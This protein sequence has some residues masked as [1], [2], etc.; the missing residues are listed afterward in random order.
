MKK[1]LIILLI[2]LATLSVV[3]ADEKKADFESQMISFD[4][5][6]LSYFI[7]NYYHQ[8]KNDAFMRDGDWINSLEKQL[9]LDGFSTT[10]EDLIKV[11]DESTSPINLLESINLIHLENQKNTI[12]DYLECDEIRICFATPYLS[13]PMSY[14]GHIFIEFYNADNPLFSYVLSY[15]G[16]TKDISKFDIYKKGILGTLDGKYTIQPFFNFYDKY[17]V[18]ENRNIISYKINLN[19]DQKKEFKTIIAD[20]YFIHQDYSFIFY[21]CMDGLMDL[22]TQ[23][24]DVNLSSSFINAPADLINKLIESKL[25]SDKLVYASY[26]ENQNNMYYSLS[27]QEK[28]QFNFLMNTSDRVK[29]LESLDSEYRLKLGSL[30]SS[31][32]YY[33]FHH[34]NKYN[35]DYI[36]IINMSVPNLPIVTNDIDTFI[37]TNT[38]FI[39]LDFLSSNNQE[40]KLKLTFRP[41][42]SDIGEQYYSDYSQGA[43]EIGKVSATFNKDEFELEQFSWIKLSSLNRL[44]R[45]KKNMSWNFEL[46]NKLIDDKYPLVIDY[47]LGYSFG[48]K[49]LYIFSY[50]KNQFQSNNLNYSASVGVSFNY[51]ITNKFLL[52]IK[53]EETFF[54]EN[55]FKLEGNGEALINYFLTNDIAIN[56]T[57]KSLNNEFTFGLK[58]YFNLI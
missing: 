39:Q 11:I 46:K 42:F 51:F 4:S 27:K 12:Y 22:L 45:F 19:E 41:L 50:L 13:N 15:L 5:A 8:I 23:V 55:E 24:D 28:D 47:D 48:L 32:Y 49:N 52:Q 56:S 10:R 53:G 1:L 7:T 6:N 40:N 31:N 9:Y 29:Y 30:I 43:I 18:N 54:T 25:L 26:T 21:N 35:S 34:N 20:N 2:T 17:I 38:G 57:Y 58:Y 14:F 37:P 3:N 44:S 33:N 36:N 16:N